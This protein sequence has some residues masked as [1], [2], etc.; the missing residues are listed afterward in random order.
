MTQDG[1]LKELAQDIGGKLVQALNSLTTSLKG[2]VSLWSSLPDG[3]SSAVGA[4]I[5]G[6]MLFGPRARRSS[7]A[8]RTCSS[9][10]RSP[11]TGS[12]VPFLATYL[13][14]ITCGANRQELEQHLDDADAERMA[15]EQAKIAQMESLDDQRTQNLKAKYKAYIDGQAAAEAATAEQI[16]SIQSGLADFKA[17]KWDEITKNIKSKLKDLATEEKKI[18]GP[19]QEAAGPA[20]CRV[21]SRQKKR[22]GPCCAPRC[23]IMTP[24][25][26]K[27]K[28]ANDSLARA[29]L[30]LTGG[31][32][33]LAASWAKKAQEQFADLN[34]EIKD[35]EQTL[36][37]AANANAI[38]VTGV[39][40]AG[41]ALEQGILIQEQA[42]EAT[43]KTLAEQVSQAKTDLQTIKELQDS[44]SALEMRLS[45]DD[46]ATPVL[47]NIQSEMAKIKDKTVTVT[48]RYVK[49]GDDGRAAGGMIP[50]FNRGGKLPG[51]QPQGQHAGHGRRQVPHWSGR[52][53]VHHQ[54]HVHAAA[55][56]HDARPARKPQPRAQRWRPVPRS[57]GPSPD[58]LVAALSART[59]S[60]LPVLAKRR[61]SRPTTDPRPT[62]C[63]P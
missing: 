7:A 41:K 29:R 58:E 31:D 4:G 56:A 26:D 44:V 14:G 50:G 51:L 6:N 45:A 60:P 36:V 57:S 24:Y 5:L 13:S 55:F 25:Q 22:S 35:G 11:L 61:R 17:V 39:L 33:E 62:A 10:F 1:S 12:S 43:R 40:D 54:R 3:T 42:A 47:N 8:A 63:L 15:K 59:A 27:L 37:S 30:A 52:G 38:A 53:R 46:K 9:P 49:T 32:G 19:G 16:K 2:L 23:P 28:Q 21:R 48:V 20:C 18:L 34:T